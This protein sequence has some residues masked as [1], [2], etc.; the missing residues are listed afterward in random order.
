MLSLFRLHSPNSRFILPLLITALMVICYPL[1]TPFVVSYSQLWVNLP[2]ILLGA[3]IILSNKQPQAQSGFIA[4]VMLVAYCVIL[5]WLQTSL[6]NTDTKLI[7]CLL[8]TLLPI[9]LLLLR[10]IT[11]PKLLSWGTAALLLLVIIQCSIGATIS[12]FYHTD[13]E[14]WQQIHLFTYH[15]ISSL[16]LILILF[17]LAVCCSTGA[18]AVKYHRR[19]DRHIFVC[20]LLATT[21]FIFFHYPFISSSAFIL[22]AV[23]LLIDLGYCHYQQSFR[24]PLTQ[25]ADHR[26]LAQA[27][28]LLHHDCT[29]AV[30]DIDNPTAIIDKHHPQ[31]ISDIQASIA[32][33]LMKQTQLSPHLYFV[34]QQFI[35]IFEH[36]KITDC[37]AIIE[38]LQ[39]AIGSEKHTIVPIIIEPQPQQT[40]T[41]VKKPRKKAI[42]VSVSAGMCSANTEQTAAVVLQQAI[43]V[44]RIARQKKKKQQIYIAENNDDTLCQR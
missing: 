39:H 20:S 28:P 3:V 5:Y 14:N 21:T 31:A 29:I 12:Y 11:L 43:E 44:L 42:K 34:A 1:F 7:F 38:Q 41:K 24:D 4:I 22:C 17:N 25:L 36:K 10:F 6:A 27:L 9:N 19:I 26:A 16:P 30:L 35:M 23:F 18:L 37:Q 33:I 8:A 15:N 2:F 32:A 40:A 13:F